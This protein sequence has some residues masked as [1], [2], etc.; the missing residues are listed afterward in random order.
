MLVSGSKAAPVQAV[1][2]L[3]P[4]NCSVPFVAPGSS[5][6]TDGGVNSGPVR[7]CLMIASASARSSAVK[8]MRSSSCSPCR[9]NGGG[10]VGNGCVADVFS[11]GTFDCG[12]RRSSMGHTGLPVARSSTNTKPCLVTCDTA[13]IRRPPT[14]MSVRIGA[15]GLS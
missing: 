7:Y 1:P 12:T 2:P 3:E 6:R 13:L 10:L 5:P 11:P 14:V 15:A 8:S 4:G 9:S